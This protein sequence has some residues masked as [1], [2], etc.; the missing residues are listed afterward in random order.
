MYNK[1]YKPTKFQLIGNYLKYNRVIRGITQKEMANC[2]G[3]PYQDYQKYEYGIVIPKVNR[4][5]EI[6]NA[7]GITPNE[8]FYKLTKEKEFDEY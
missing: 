5:C 4:F 2:I 3:I 8:Q 7:L 1:H 6:C